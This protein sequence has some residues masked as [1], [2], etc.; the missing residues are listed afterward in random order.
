MSELDLLV[1]QIDGLR[2]GE[3]VL[4]NAINAIHARNHEI[5]RLLSGART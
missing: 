4:S 1:I 3:H 5:A 2:V